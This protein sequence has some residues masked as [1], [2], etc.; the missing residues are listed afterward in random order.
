MKGI[1][2]VLISGKLDTENI[3][4]RILSGI[5]LSF[6][7]FVFSQLKKKKPFPPS[8]FPPTK[9]SFIN[10]RFSFFHLRS[11]VTMV[12]ATSLILGDEMIKMPTSWNPYKV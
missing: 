9:L 6:I 10:V 8:T 1:I 12:A 7:S 3:S 11:L 5:C 4:T 2:P